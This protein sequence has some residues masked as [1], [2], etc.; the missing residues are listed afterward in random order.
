MEA[1]SQLRPIV[2]RRKPLQSALKA[3]RLRVA[4][5]RARV[6]PRPKSKKAIKEKS[7]T[8]NSHTSFSTS[9]RGIKP[10]SKDLRSNPGG[11]TVVLFSKAFNALVA[12][13]L[14]SSTWP[15]VASSDSIDDG[16]PPWT[17]PWNQKMMKTVA[18]TLSC[19]LLLQ[20][21]HFPT[22]QATL[23]QAAIPAVELVENWPLAF[24][25][26]LQRFGC[27]NVSK[28]QSECQI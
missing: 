14:W 26:R 19:N 22:M 5:F 13:S 11:N 12:A 16:K 27:W 4:R 24:L 25:I 9:A 6:H 28:S 23:A 21:E 17:F 7:S 1:S 15:P 8:K 10:I 18:K 2:C 20:I 3:Q